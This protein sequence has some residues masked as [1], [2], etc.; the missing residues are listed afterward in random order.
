[1]KYTVTTYY[2][3]NGKVERIIR[4]SYCSWVLRNERLPGCDVY[5]NLFDSFEKVKDFYDEDEFE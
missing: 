3:D 4:P 2:Y 1:M 5:V